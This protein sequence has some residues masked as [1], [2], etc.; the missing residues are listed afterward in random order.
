MRRDSIMSPRMEHSEH[1]SPHHTTQHHTT[2]HHTIP[3]HITPYHTIPH[4]TK[5]NPKHDTFPTPVEETEPTNMHLASYK[6]KQTNTFQ[7]PKT[8]S[9]RTQ[10][11]PKAPQ[12]SSPGP[13]MRPQVSQR[14]PREP[15]WNPNAPQGGPKAAKRPPKGSQKSPKSGPKGHPE[16]DPKQI[17]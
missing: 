6:K 3:H 13:K 1:L 7:A 8:T 17:G 16:G 15:Q 11:H 2:P 4:H 9:K 12:N 5:S 14:R 10:W